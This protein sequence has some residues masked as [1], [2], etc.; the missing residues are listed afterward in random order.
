M[1]PG[2]GLT[3]AK[4][5]TA[6]R[7]LAKRAG[8]AEKGS[9]EAAKD[10]GTH[11]HPCDFVLPCMLR[12]RR[13]RGRQR[14]AGRAKRPGCL[15]VHALGGRVR[16]GGEGF[17]MIIIPLNACFFHFFTFSF[18]L[19][20]S[21]CVCV[22]VSGAFVSARDTSQPGSVMHFSVHRDSST[23]SSC[24]LDLDA[25]PRIN[26][27]CSFLS[28]PSSALRLTLPSLLVGRFLF[29]AEQLLL[30]PGCETPS[31]PTWPCRRRAARLT[32]TCTSRS[33]PRS[34]TSR[35]R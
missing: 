30:W 6:L 3:P 31:T 24:M 34:W 2:G 13:E 19:S 28:S 12:G 14:E 27:T 4:V 33:A 26:A 35:R 21:F 32:D 5:A 22:C 1:A 9:E 25:P 29:R 11:I 20:R 23:V 10:R 7:Y 8:D 15:F 16:G 18:C 17:L